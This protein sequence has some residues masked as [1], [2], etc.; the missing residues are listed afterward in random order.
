MSSNERNQ[1]I[2]CLQFMYELFFFIIII[3]IC[4]PTFLAVYTLL[5]LHLCH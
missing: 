1:Q 4:V 5:L 2:N 3:F